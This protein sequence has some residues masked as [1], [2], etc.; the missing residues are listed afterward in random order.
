MPITIVGVIAPHF[1]GIQQ[2]VANPP[3]ISL[4]LSLDAQLTT[5]PPST[6]RL[7]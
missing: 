1:F 4:P 2:P 7:G 6:D 3:D 5:G